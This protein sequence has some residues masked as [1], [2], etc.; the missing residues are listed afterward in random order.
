MR[1]DAESRDE[2]R[3]PLFALTP[4]FSLGERVPRLSGCSKIVALVLLL[5]TSNLSAAIRL[6][7]FVGYDGILTQ[8]GF[9]PVVFEVFNDGP[10]F[11]GLLEL[12]PGQFGQ[13]Q[14]REVPVELPTGTLK[15]IVIPVFSAQQYGSSSWNIRLIDDRRRLRAETTSRPIR[16]NNPFGIPLLAAVTRTPPLLPEVKASGQDMKPIVARLQPDLFPD[17]PIALEGLDT[18]Y[19]SSERALDLKVNQVNALLAWLQ[20]GGHL[21]VGVEQIIHVNGAEWLHDLLP[22]EFTDLTTVNL[23]SELQRW[24]TSGLGRTG[25]SIYDVSISVDNP[26][27]KLKPDDHFESQPIQVATGKKRDGQVLIGTETT[28]LA[29][30]ARRGRGQITVLTFAPELEPFASW[31]NRPH[32]WAKMLNLP[33]EMLEKTEYYRYAGYSLDGVFGAMIDSKQVRK[34]PVGWLLLL[35]VGYLIVIGPLDRYWLRKLGKQMLT[36]IT[37]PIYVALFSGLIYFIGY[38]L[39]AGET[40]WNELQV[41]DVIP[42]GERAIARGHTFASVYSPVNAS[43]QLAGQQ[44]FSTLRGEFMRTA[45]GQETSKAIVRQQG[46]GFEAEISVPVW[47]SQLYVNEWWTQGPLPLQVS[48]ASRGVD[49][50]IT[51]DNRLDTK[52]TSVMVAVEKRLYNLGDVPARQG[53]TVTV[54]KGSGE[55]LDSFVQTQGGHF[56]QVVNQRQAAFGYNEQWR[57]SDTVRSAVA[58]S[59]VSRTQPASPR[60]GQPY[61]GGYNYAMT[62]PGFDLYELVRRGD[63][64]VLAWAPGYGVTKPINQFSARRGQRD[65][66]LRV[67]VPVQL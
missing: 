12:T 39:R 31:I 20:A 19:L 5:L 22:C 25:Q 13:G 14:V 60:Q 65:S 21:V 9:F 33:T 43:Y 48:V 41:V 67:S 42:N 53:R 52:L 64:V 63:A 11:K 50:V 6:D 57:I 29:W 1:C 44:P 51:V 34:L 59:F 36:W 58:A 30:T 61:Y 4:A 32:F 8:G 16:K 40:E 26:Y 56:M 66:L 24:V 18:I 23:H 37:F 55:S 35:L 45:G 62:P 3:K 15:R 10:G 47:T 49:W 28:P 2:V 27:A 7:V 38:K 46:N 54:R 17:N